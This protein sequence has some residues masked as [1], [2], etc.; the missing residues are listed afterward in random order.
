VVPVLSD[1]SEERIASIF[2][3]G[4]EHGI[5]VKHVLYVL[6]LHTSIM[7]VNIFDEGALQLVLISTLSI[8]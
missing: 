2:R 6:I 1:V 7:F 5:T 3:A 8:L 4:V